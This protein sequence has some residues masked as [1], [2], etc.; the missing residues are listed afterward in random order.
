MLCEERPVQ[1]LAKLTGRRASVRKHECK[2]LGLDQ[3][4]ANSSMGRPWEGGA[5]VKSQWSG[6]RER[7]DCEGDEEVL[8]SIIDIADPAPRGA[9]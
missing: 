4:L 3:G 5:D 2:A 8:D 9:S 6:R 7:D 1:G